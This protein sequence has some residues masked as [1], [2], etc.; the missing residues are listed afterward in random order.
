MN[1]IKFVFAFSLFS[2]YIIGQ[3]QLTND[4]LKSFEFTQKRQYYN[5]NDKLVFQAFRRDLGYETWIMDSTFSTYLLK[6]FV[7]G[8]FSG[9]NSKSYGGNSDYFYW[10]TLTSDLVRSDG[11]ADGTSILESYDIQSNKATIV[12]NNVVY[13][14]NNSGIE[15]YDPQSGNIDSINEVVE[16]FIF[17]TSL[18]GIEDYLLFSTRNFSYSEKFLWYTDGTSNGTKRIPSDGLHFIDYTYHNGHIYFSADS[19]DISPINIYKYSIE[20][21]SISLLFQTDFEDMDNDYFFRNSPTLLSDKL[22]FSL[23]DEDFNFKIYSV[24]INTD[25]VDVVFESN[26]MSEHVSPKFHKGDLYFATNESLYSID[27]LGQVKELLGLHNSGFSSF[28]DDMFLKF[29]SDNKILIGEKKPYGDKTIFTL[30]DIITQVGKELEVSD[31]PEEAQILNNKIVIPFS[32]RADGDFGIINDDFTDIEKY[33]RINEEPVGLITPVFETDHN[34][35]NTVRIGNSYIFRCY[36]VEK[37]TQWCALDMEDMSISSIAKTDLQSNNDPVI[38]YHDEE[39]IIYKELYY[40]IDL[41]LINLDLNSGVVSKIKLDN[42]ALKARNI[43]KFQN[44]IVILSD[45]N[46]MY[47]LDGTNPIPLFEFGL[48]NVES[49]SWG[50]EDKIVVF[51]GSIKVIKDFNGYEEL[52]GSISFFYEESQCDGDYIYIVYDLTQ[53]FR[54]N[55]NTGE[56]T[57]IDLDGSAFRRLYLK[58]DGNVFLFNASGRKY[59]LWLSDFSESEIKK[60]YTYEELPPSHGPGKGVILNNQ[61]YFLGNST[62]YGSEL[63]VSDGTAEGTK[64]VA[65]FNPG[66]GHSN[67]TLDK[68]ENRLFINAF[69]TEK[70]LE[71]YTIDLVNN[72]II[73]LGDVIQGQRGSYATNPIFFKDGAFYLADS[74]DDGIQLFYSNIVPSSSYDIDLENHLVEVSPNPTSGLVNVPQGLDIYAV[75]IYS[76]D[77][78]ILKDKTLNGEN[79]INLRKYPPGTYFIKWTGNQFTYTSKVIKEN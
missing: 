40:S 3:T 29:T 79:V 42:K 70:G 48:S 47:K 41:N 71:P 11:T 44:E 24:D 31:F 68:S 5:F 26:N 60:V 8:N 75:K 13:V 50:F 6:D 67:L 52:L 53:L 45:D 36:G 59:E 69:T 12:H 34:K 32:F 46:I 14:Y 49:K 18:T 2:C 7:D 28:E 62:D 27:S 17:E 54:M 4:T 61:L 21:D 22:Y 15:S 38:L 25:I 19:A 74:K 35:R 55:L 51:D 63:W 58:E 56:Y 10:N 37:K 43:L 23:A 78:Q 16:G 73:P 33:I 77:G 65:D 57:F 1:R 20:N 66:S 72:E 9:I 76:V 39:R 30:F 64:M